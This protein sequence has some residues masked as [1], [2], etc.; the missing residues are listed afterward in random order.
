[1]L[2][3]A[4]GSSVA[5]G[6][7]V[8]GPNGVATV[9]INGAA[10]KLSG[11]TFSADVTTRF[12]ANFADIVATDTKGAKST[13]TCSFLVADQWAPEEA[14][15]ADT[16]DMKLTQGAI[17]DGDRSGEVH[18]LADILHTIANSPA[19]Q[20]QA[21]QTLLA[22]RLP[23]AVLPLA[24]Q[25]QACSPPIGVIPGTC[26][27]QYS[28]GVD[29]LGVSLPGPQSVSMALVDGGI[30]VTVTV[31]NI[32]LNLDVHGG[33]GAVPYDIRGWVT[34]AYA[35]V[36]MTLDTALSNGQLKMTLRPK[37]TAASVGPVATNFQGLDGWIINNVVIPFAQ[38]YIQNTVSTM[39]PSAVTP[40]A[41]NGGM[42]A[43]F[44]GLIFSPFGTSK[45][46]ALGA[47]DSTIPLSFGYSVTS[48]STTPSEMLIGVGTRLSAPK[49]QT[50]P[51]LGIAIP[52]GMVLDDPP[53]NAPNTTG[54]AVHVGVLN[55]AL[56]ALWRGGMFDT[57]VTGA[58]FGNGLMP[59]AARVKLTSLLPPVANF[60]GNSVELSLGGLHLDVSAPG[61]LAGQQ[62]A[63]DVGARLMSTPSLDGKSLEFGSTTLSELHFS[64][65]DVSLDPTTEQ[66]LRL[67]LQNLIQELALHSL[68]E[69][70]PAVPMPSLVLPLNVQGGL[71]AMT[72]LT[73]ASL[74]NDANDFVLLGQFGPQ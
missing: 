52:H 68:D 53:V 47:S 31:P 13:R 20:G 36:T 57:T 25:Q 12:G 2:D 7:T 73:H 56:H 48:L 59:A 38:G 41:L 14:L 49:T 61:I 72:G 35:R 27:C 23:Q 1:M 60:V 28:A 9:T 50:L 69:A 21:L 74:G 58:D 4:P 10:A 54:V 44:S 18:S 34:V 22:D 63:V 24:C 55:Q 33:V 11:T 8:S 15:Y 71:S 62:L 40:G 66:E 64:T 29:L 67:L 46:H 43:I 70:L 42:G 45:V 5:F 32:G 65:G 6:G 16:V 17:D 39:V 51:S 37:S 30:S 26:L 3:V 19:L